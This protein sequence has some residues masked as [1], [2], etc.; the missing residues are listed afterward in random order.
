MARKTRY[1]R[2]PEKLLGWTPEPGGPVTALE[3]LIYEAKFFMLSQMY[4]WAEAGLAFPLESV[5]NPRGNVRLWA[6]ADSSSV[7]CVAVEVFFDNA[8]RDPVA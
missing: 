7:V 3:W 1:D 6:Y 2:Q 8:W 5:T 4:D